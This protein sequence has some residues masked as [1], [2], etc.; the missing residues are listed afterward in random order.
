MSNASPLNLSDA[1]TKGFE[2]IDPGRYNAEI[3]EITWDAVKNAG[4][5]TPVGTPMLKIQFRLTDEGVANRRVFTQYVVPP[6]DYDAQKKATMNGMIARFFMALGYTEEQVKDKKFNPDFEDLKGK[7]C[8]V[9]LGREQKK[10]K[11]GNLIEGEFNNPVKGIK[12]A[13]S[14]ATGATSGG[15][16]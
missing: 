13:G 6:A 12:E 2:A 3:F 4:G 5:K 15:L 10:D 1:D 7:E 8:V 11:D 14:I 9:V 16:L